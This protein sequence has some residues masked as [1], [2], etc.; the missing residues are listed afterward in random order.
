MDF[1]ETLIEAFESLRNLVGLR[2]MA[3]AIATPIYF[4][5][6]NGLKSIFIKKIPQIPTLSEKS[7]E[8]LLTLT[9]GTRR[10]ILFAFA[11]YF[12]TWLLV[13][14]PNMHALTG[15]LAIMF[16]AIQIALW[17][18]LILQHLIQKHLED[19]H[20][21]DATVATA[22]GLLN[23]AL[24]VVLFTTVGL[25]VLSNFGVD[26]TALIT[27]LG[28]GG[29]AVALALQNVLGDLFASL[30]I[31][32]DKPFVVGDFVTVGD[33]TGTIEKVG[34][35]TTRVRSLSGE[36]VI[37]SNNDI[38]Q[39][40]IRNLQRLTQRRVVL[41]LGVTY[42]TKKS[43]LTAINN[44]VKKSIEAEPQVR[45]DRVFFVNFGQSSLDIEAVYWVL[46]PDHTAFLEAQQNINFR[47]LEG[48]EEMHVSFAFPTRQIFIQNA[49]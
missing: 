21:K 42:G 28:I 6:F 13:L 35:K 30:T 44:M 40:R 41:T 18:Q 9:R 24:R 20:S 38:L 3:A 2:W 11:I 27:G 5:G 23:F 49:P 26:I 43:Q 7:K 4:M 37:F 10:W 8:L 34:I 12:A 19:E 45:F 29:V 16:A 47:I 46:T 48:L 17:G 22:F 39:S 15:K 1:A 33:I 25:I 14:K 31:V 32:L 36:E